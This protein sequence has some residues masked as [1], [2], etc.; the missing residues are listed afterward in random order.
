MK[1]TIIMC[2][3]PHDAAFLSRVM[4]EDSFKTYN[5]KLIDYPIFVR[6]FLLKQ[7]NTGSLEDYNLKV[8]RGGLFLPAFALNKDD[9][10]ILI[11]NLGGDSKKDARN[12]IV[13]SFNILLREAKSGLS[14][15]LLSEGD[16]LSIVYFYDADEKGIQSRVD[17]VKEEIKEFLGI[18]RDIDIDHAK[19]CEE[20]DLRFGL[21]VFA[22]TE[23]SKGKLEDL[24][25]PLMKNNNDDIFVDVESIVCKRKERYYKL[26][27]TPVKKRDKD[28]DEKK[29]MIGMMGQLQKSGS[30]NST[31]I[32]Q[33]DLIDSDGIAKDANCQRIISFLE[34]SFRA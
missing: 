7:L 29:A 19:Y 16:Q 15:N 33:S 1:V 13:S 24:V 9:S 11:Y 26:F 18:K 3:G 32:E 21:Y 30:P 23:T 22:N 4:H 27:C 8:A 28:F 34:D 31:I 6:G 14:G 20:G 12:R 25:L 17:E 10:L 2:E 5:N